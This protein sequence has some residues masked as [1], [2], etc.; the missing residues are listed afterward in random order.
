MTS[1]LTASLVG[2]VFAVIHVV[3]GIEARRSGYHRF[4][5][6]AGFLRGK[7]LPWRVLLWCGV[8]EGVVALA[9]VVI[10]LTAY[11]PGVREFDIS[12]PAGWH[13]LSDGVRN[14]PPPEAGLDAAAIR[15]GSPGA[16]SIG[17]VVD[18]GRPSIFLTSLATGTWTA[19]LDHLV[20]AAEKQAE[21]VHAATGVRPEI[22]HYELLEVQ[23]VLSG[24]YLAIIRFADETRVV[25]SYILPGRASKAWLVYS[26]DERDYSKHLPEFLQLVEHARQD[27]VF[28]FPFRPMYLVLAGLLI[29]G[30]VT[31]VCATKQPPPLPTARVVAERDVG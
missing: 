12:V 13:D 18:E 28:V 22:G 21:G 11:P 30:I 5:R 25:L 7:W 10:A 27:W 29:A 6:R 23:G 4:G 19:T 31:M 16:A 3:Q 2:L 14:L 1:W 15:A 20:R 17:A 26:A 8:G 24:K 9:A